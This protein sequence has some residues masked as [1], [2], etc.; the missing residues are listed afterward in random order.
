MANHPDCFLRSLISGHVT[1]SAWLVNGD[2]SKV[3]LTHHRKLERWL[4]PGGHADGDPD[5]LAVALR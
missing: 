2:G 5:L 4:Q 3:M 1:G